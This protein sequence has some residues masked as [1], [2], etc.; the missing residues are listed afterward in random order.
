MLL[1]KDRGKFV[2]KINYDEVR[3]GPG[4]L[5]AATPDIYPY[6]TGDRALTFLCA[7]CARRRRAKGG[8]AELTVDAD[9]MYSED[10]RCADCAP[11]EKS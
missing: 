11:K 9:D 6:L 8:R 5:G 3:G 10:A 4:E 1:Q 7:P 2:G